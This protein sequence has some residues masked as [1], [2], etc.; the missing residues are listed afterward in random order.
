MLDIFLSVIHD[1]GKYDDRHGEREEHE[2]ELAHARL[3]RHAEDSEAGRVPRKL[4][5]AKDPKDPESDERAAHLVIGDN[6]ERYVV[7]KYGDHVDHAHHGACVV[8]ARGRR[9]QAQEILGREYGHACRVKR[10][11][12]VLVLFAKCLCF[13]YFRIGR[14]H[15]G[16][17]CLAY[18]GAHTDR[19]EK[20]RHVIEDE[21]HRARLRILERVP[22]AFADG[23]RAV[24]IALVVVDLLLVEALVVLAFAV[25]I[26]LV[27]AVGHEVRHDAKE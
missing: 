3:Q 17:E 1:C 18:V 20:A 21:R 19:Y 22:Q 2:A 26:L 10:K 5:Y 14:L 27:A 12:L 23:H 4:E 25:A 6:H 24:G 8:A 13:E 16:L 9:I 7:R 11:K 15:R